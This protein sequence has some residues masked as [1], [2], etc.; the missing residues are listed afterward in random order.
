MTIIIVTVS[1]SKVTLLYIVDTMNIPNIVGVS[2]SRSEHV[3]F[4]FE[5]IN[6]R[7]GLLV[8]TI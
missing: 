3:N 2:K 1:E 8:T 4:S 6:H 7:N 5:I